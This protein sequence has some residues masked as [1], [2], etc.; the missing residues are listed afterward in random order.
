M[1]MIAR[2]S[3]CYCLERIGFCNAAHIGPKPCLNFI[4]DQW[5]T[6]LGSEHTMKE[7]AGVR[8]GTGILFSRPWRD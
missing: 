5:S 3:H 7:E 8:H 1:N 4:F 6:A 2:A